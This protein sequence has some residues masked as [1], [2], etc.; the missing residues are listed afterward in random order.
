MVWIFT[1]SCNLSCLHC[2]VWRLRNLAELELG[3]KL[4]LAEELAELGVGYV[5][6]TGGEPLLHPHFESVTS[7]LK[8]LGV[9][10]SISTNA[11]IV[12]EELASLLSR[13]EV[14]AYVSLDGPREVHNKVRGAGAFKRVLKGIENL[15]RAGLGFTLVMAVGRHNYRY[16]DKVVELAVRLG[17]K[18]VA[19]IPIMP[20]G[21]ARETGVYAGV[22]Q[23]LE[24]L[25]LAE[26]KAEELGF[27]TALWCTPFAPHVVR[28]RYVRYSF[29]RSLD[30]ADVDPSGR[31]LLCDVIDVSPAS[32]RSSGSFAEA[33]RRYSRHP[34]VQE[35]ISPK[36]LPEPCEKCVLRSS[37]RGG[38]FARALLVY[39][40]LNAGDPL[41]PVR[42]GLL[43]SSSREAL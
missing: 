19:L 13:L 11:T 12:D 27:P 29:C 4:R 9:G 38:C 18:E 10:L 39:G 8:E 1:T 28:S 33:W 16:A 43:S 36:K 6:I 30:V 3:E 40:E 2:Y 32:I 22:V 15:K 31:L 41:C 25:K 34:T 35:V 26:N 20:S 23:Y 14:Y 42:R 5:N 7:K 17:A 37:C 21:R 24:A